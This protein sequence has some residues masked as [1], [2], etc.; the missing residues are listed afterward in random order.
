MMMAVALVL[1]AA[2][3]VGAQST[4]RHPGLLHTE[5]DFEQVRARVAAEESLSQEALT[6]LKTSPGVRGDHGHNWGVNEVIKRGV[7]GDENYL[8]AYRNAARPCRGCLPASMWWAAKWCAMV[9]GSHGQ[10]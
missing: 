7:S 2:G 10:P 9:A 4:F 6:Y 5:A 1:L 8:N 3:R